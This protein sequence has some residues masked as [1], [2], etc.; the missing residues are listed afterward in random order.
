[1]LKV[2]SKFVSKNV[3]KIADVRIQCIF[4]HKERTI[5]FVCS[6][7]R[8]KRMKTYIVY[9][10]LITSFA[11][12]HNPRKY[13]QRKVSYKFEKHAILRFKLSEKV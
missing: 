8:Q 10:S 3:S 4:N 13:E 2:V 12:K 6:Q 7:I 9:F 1:M 11:L 5:S